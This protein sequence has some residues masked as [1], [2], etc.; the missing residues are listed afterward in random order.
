[1]EHLINHATQQPPTV[2]VTTAGM[3]LLFAICAIIL[4]MMNW[5]ERKD[6]K[7]RNNK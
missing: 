3:A 4:T 6:I 5:E 1:M 7:R 2:H